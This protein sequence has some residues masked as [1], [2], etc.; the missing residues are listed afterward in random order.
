[1][2][3]CVCIL[4][5]LLFVLTMNAQSFNESLH[6]EQYAESN[7]RIKA[8]GKTPTAVF[9]GNSIIDIWAR[10]YGSFFTSY[11]YLGRG[12]GGHT[13]PQMLLRFRPDVLELKPKAVVICIGINDIAENT[14]PYSEQF[15]FD[16]ISTCADLARAYGI[17]VILCSI[18]PAAKCGWNKSVVNVPAKID[19]LN[20]R[21][22]DYAEK[23][24]II[25]VDF[26]T[27]MR[28][29]NGGLKKEYDWDDGVH[30][31][32]KGYKIMESIIVPVINKVLVNE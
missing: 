6:L 17:K 31:N 5:V 14:G 22:K 10:D 11:D 9:I 32:E 23:E 28:D 12:V 13:S 25:F 7:A 30:I 27:A 2:K 16:N 20:A 24:K 29:E 19:A 8:S 15:T 4:V 26:N 1:M 21:I 3:R 18:L